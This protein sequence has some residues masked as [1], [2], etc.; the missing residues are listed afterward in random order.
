MFW[1]TDPSDQYWNTY[2]YCG[3]DPIN[4]TDPDGEFAYAA[5]FW[6]M[7]L[8]GAAIGG[9]SAAANG[10]DWSDILMGAGVGFVAGAMVGAVPVGLAQ[11][12][13]SFGSAAGTAA[14]TATQ[15][16]TGAGQGALQ[17]ASLL[18]QGASFLTNMQLALNDPGGGAASQ[19]DFYRWR[20]DQIWKQM[21][22][23][24]LNQVKNMSVADLPVGAGIKIVKGVKAGSKIVKGLKKG[25]HLFKYITK[26]YKL[27]GRALEEFSNRVHEIK[28]MSGRGGAANLSKEELEKIAK[29]VLEDLGKWRK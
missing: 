16:S 17:A 4:Y 29:E 24:Y 28:R 10:G 1:S 18:S 11:A 7:A 13:V 20:Q 25:E 12:G 27:T 26:K 15:V 21:E 8:S 3:G 5:F 23:E 2:V 22:A 6:T 19:S 14:Q 9:I